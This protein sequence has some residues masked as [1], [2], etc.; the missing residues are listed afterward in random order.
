MYFK[1]STHQYIIN[2]KPYTSFSSIIKIVEPEKD[3]NEIAEKYAKKHS[4]KKNPLTKEGVQKQWS[5]E[6]RVAR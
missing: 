5:E 1:Q 3:W 2:E 6:G 4:T